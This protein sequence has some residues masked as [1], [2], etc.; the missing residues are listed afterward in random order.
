[1]NAPNPA[2][3]LP[4]GFFA[5]SATAPMFLGGGLVGLYVPTLFPSLADPPVAWSLIGVGAVFEAWAV[6]IL[7]G[8]MRRN[9]ARR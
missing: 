9:A 1:M 8:A 2:L 6:V 7:I 5:L 4:P 3:K